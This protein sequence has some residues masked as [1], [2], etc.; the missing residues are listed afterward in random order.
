MPEIIHIESLRDSR[1]ECGFPNPRSGYFRLRR[2]KTSL[3]GANL[4]ACYAPEG[5]APGKARN[6]VTKEKATRLPLISCAPRFR[7][8]LIEGI[9]LSLD[10]RAE[11]FPRP[12]RASPAEDCGARRGKRDMAAERKQRIKPKRRKGTKHKG[13]SYKALATRNPRMPPASSD[14]SLTRLAERRFSGMLSHEPPRTTRPSSFP[15]SQAPP[16]VGVTL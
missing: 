8:G 7:R 14:Q 9:S 4:V 16:S 12:Y 6:S 11:S 3:P 10:Q 5:F 15:A 1:L 2:Q 13:Q